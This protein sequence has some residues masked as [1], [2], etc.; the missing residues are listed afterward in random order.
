MGVDNLGIASHRIEAMK[1]FDLFSFMLWM[2]LETKLRFAAF[3][4]C[5]SDGE[6]G[7]TSIL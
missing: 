6:V 3:R 7:G 1:A 4:R 5:C 2:R